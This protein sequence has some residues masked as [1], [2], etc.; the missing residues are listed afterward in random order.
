MKLKN[1]LYGILIFVVSVA[2]EFIGTYA[3]QVYNDETIDSKLKVHY[4]DVGQGDATF[5]E[6]PNG[7]TILID[8]GEVEA[9]HAVVNYIKK[10]KYQKIDYVFATHP[11]SDHIG[12]MALVI[13]SFNIGSIYMPEVTNNSNIYLNLLKTI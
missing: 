9:G 11:H 7:K 2:L 6:L 4:I 13:N 8:A 1:I 5:I 3:Y 12:G 10:L